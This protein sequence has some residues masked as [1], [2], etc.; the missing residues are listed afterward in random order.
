LKHVLHLH[1][2]SSPQISQFIVG[3]NLVPHTRQDSLLNKPG[4]YSMKKIL[5]FIGSISILDI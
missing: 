4:P 2:I 3:I 1:E 5:Q